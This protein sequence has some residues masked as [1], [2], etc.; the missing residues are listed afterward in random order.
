M[1][2]YFRLLGLYSQRFL[3]LEKVLF[4][5]F[6][7]EWFLRILLRIRICYS[8]NHYALNNVRIRSKL[9]GTEH[10]YFGDYSACSAAI[11]H[12]DQSVTYLVVHSVYCTLKQDM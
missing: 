12:T 10:A 4:L 7:L 6:F 2:N 11:R 3:F 9:T 5:E 1:G 8:Q